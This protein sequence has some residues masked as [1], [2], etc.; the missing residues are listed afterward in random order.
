YF[1][2]KDLAA[3]EAALRERRF[4]KPAGFDAWWTPVGL[5]DGT[6][7]NYGFGWGIVEQRGQ[8]LIEHGGSWQGFRSTIARYVDQGLAV[9]VLANLAQAE[10]QNMAPEIAGL[11]GPPLQH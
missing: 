5:A 11:G 3:W 7:Y 8:R 10:P 1:T 6:T 4:L 9:I 2:V